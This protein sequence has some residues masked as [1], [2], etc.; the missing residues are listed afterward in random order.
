M[1]AKIS[2]SVV[3]KNR[4]QPSHTMSQSRPCQI[5]EMQPLGFARQPETNNRSQDT[6]VDFIHATGLT[7]E[8]WDMTLG[9]KPD[10]IFFALQVVP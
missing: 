8:A 3:C 7:R 6:L 9:P 1:L 5:D 10:I 4:K 2:D